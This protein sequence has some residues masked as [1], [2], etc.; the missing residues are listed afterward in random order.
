[1]R[2]LAIVSVKGGTGKTT[3]AV[4]LGASLAIQGQK[5]LLV[6][7]DAQGSLTKSLGFTPDTL[8]HTLFN[9]MT[10]AI[11]DPN[12]LL[13]VAE[14]TVLHYER[15]GEGNNSL[16][17]K[18]DLIPAN[19][20]L[21]N[22][23]TRLVVMQTS[24]A[25]FDSDDE[26]RS[27]YVMRTALDVIKERYDYVLIDCGPKVDLQM[28]NALAA[29]D[30]VIV[31]VQAHYLDS[32]GLPDTLDIIRKVRKNYNAGLKIRGILLTMFQSRTKLA[33][34][35]RENLADLYGQEVPIFDHP[36]DYSVRVAEHPVSGDTIF[37]YEPSAPAAQ[38]Y[39]AVAKEV[40]DNG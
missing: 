24:G 1:M 35:V 37:T 16:N 31:P 3:T 36:I 14:K 40:V 26:T 22:I 39:A 13:S 20:R 7:N 15:S 12:D 28:I 19:K 11:E 4:N 9:L 38:A 21:T 8:E 27:E 30:E 2:T 32:E 25:M 33:R 29:A 10:K 17:V 18:L 6:D 5:V 34:L 23:L